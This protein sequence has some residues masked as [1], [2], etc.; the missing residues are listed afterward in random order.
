MTLDAAD[1]TF[2]AYRSVAA[3]RADGEVPTGED[4]V[5]VARLDDDDFAAVRALVARRAAVERSLV[6][7]TG[8]LARVASASAGDAAGMALVAV[9]ANH[10]AGVDSLRAYWDDVLDGEEHARGND[11]TGLDARQWLADADLDRAGDAVDDGV[12]GTE[13]TPDA[14]VGALEHLLTGE[15]LV[16]GLCVALSATVDGRVGGVPTLDGLARV[17]DRGSAA[18]AEHVRA[19]DAVATALDADA[20]LEP[21]ASDAAAATLRAALPELPAAVSV[22]AVVDEVV[23]TQRSAVGGSE[24]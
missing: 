17:A 16:G 13:L 3:A 18:T 19:A 5:R 11:L 6:A 14:V 2:R 8:G 24:D 4:R 9:A 10:A 21:P 12:T 7:P 15:L 22:E 23:T 1:P 20:T